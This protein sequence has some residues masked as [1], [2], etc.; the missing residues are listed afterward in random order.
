MRP[1][2][3]MAKMPERTNKRR[4]NW[5]KTSNSTFKNIASIQFKPHWNVAMPS[6]NI[7]PEKTSFSGFDEGIDNNTVLIAVSWVNLE[8]SFKKNFQEDSLKPSAH[9]A[10]LPIVNHV[11]Q[12]KLNLLAKYF[13]LR[14][15]RVSLH[16]YLKGF[17]SLQSRWFCERVLSIFLTKNN[18]RHLILM[19]AKGW[20]ENIVE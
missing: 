20:G 4:I 6:L 1:T 8:T 17:S 16:I 2:F 18:G 10:E 19:V 5:I 3:A 7:Y 13:F 12:I 14:T 15:K 11:P 9:L